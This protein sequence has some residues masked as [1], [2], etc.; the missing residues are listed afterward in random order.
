MSVTHSAGRE[1][2]GTGKGPASV[3]AR[4][5]GRPR[6]VVAR[7]TPDLTNTAGFS[8]VDLGESARVSLM[9][10]P[11]P[12]GAFADQANETLAAMAAVLQK[13]RQRMIVTSQ[14]VFLR[15]SAHQ[16]ECER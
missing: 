10:T 7:I 8:V 9:L 3:L 5:E 1:R 2:K 13:T 12:R 14:T 16:P 15:D 6:M 4:S 11:E